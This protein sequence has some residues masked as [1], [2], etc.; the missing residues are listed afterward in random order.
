LGVD[1]VSRYGWPGVRPVLA[2]FSNS[3]SSGQ[4]HIYMAGERYVSVHPRC[5]G[6]TATGCVLLL[7]PRYLNHRVILPVVGASPSQLNFLSAK[8]GVLKADKKMDGV[9]Q[10]SAIARHMAEG[11]RPRP[12]LSIPGGPPLDHASSRI[13]LGAGA[14]MSRHVCP[15]K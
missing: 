10:L 2:A 15:N 6:W 13:I 5:I 11:N 9:H 3:S 4:M 7:H 14:A 8:G 1:E 12:E